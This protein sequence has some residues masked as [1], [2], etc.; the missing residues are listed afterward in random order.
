MKLAMLQ[1]GLKEIFLLNK[2]HFFPTQW[3][4]FNNKQSS[5]CCLDQENLPTEENNADLFSFICSL[6]K[7]QN[8]WINFL[9]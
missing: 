8:I 9:G 5:E 6:T 1:Q 2:E 4:T 7:E 3:I